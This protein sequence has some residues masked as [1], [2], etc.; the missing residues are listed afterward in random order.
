MTT[1]Y[2]SGS[3]S[4][5]VNLNMH[6]SY[7]LYRYDRF[8]NE[9]EPMFTIPEPHGCLRKRKP[10]FKHLG[11]VGSAQARLRKKEGKDPSQ[12]LY[13]L[14]CKQQQHG[15]RT[16]GSHPGADEKPCVPQPWLVPSVMSLNT[17]GYAY[18]TGLIKPTLLLPAHRRS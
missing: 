4:S 5:V 17:S 15:A 8:S 10:E 11:I 9:V 7:P 13:I 2:V 3:D 14:Q 18:A 6:E 16:T 1:Q 12:H